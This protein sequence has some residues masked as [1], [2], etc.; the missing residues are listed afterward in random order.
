MI[1]QIEL[2]LLPEEAAD[3]SIQRQKASELLAVPENEITFI[4]ILK[5]S[6]DARSRTVK[7]RLQAE[8]YIDENPQPE[9]NLRELFHF[10]RN[11]SGQPAVI[12]VGAGPAGLFAALRLIELNLKPILVE[13]GKDVQSRRRDLAAINKQ[14]II[15]PDSNYCVGEGGAST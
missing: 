3:K 8:A 12:I 5:R 6:I 11:V 13:R 7:I 9:K 15:N 4:K 1:K 14:H 2:V 10:D